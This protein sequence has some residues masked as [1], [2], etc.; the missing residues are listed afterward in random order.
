[1]ARTKR[2]DPH[3][4]GALI[5]A[6]YEHVLYYSLRTTEDGWPVP[7]SG[8]DC[9]T[10]GMREEKGADGTV[11]F[12][13][14][15]HRRDDCCVMRLREVAAFA[16]HGGP[17]SC[18]A[19]GAQ[20]KHGAVWKHTL[21]GEHIHLGYDCERNYSL[22]AD[23]SAH[24][25]KLGRLRKAAAVQCERARRSD[26]RSTFLA[27]NP[28]LEEALKT[29]HHIVRNI[30]ERFTASKFCALSDKQ[31]AL[32]MKLAHEAAQPK[33]EEK[34]VSAPTGRVDFIGEV[35]SVKT[36]D[37]DYGVQLKM[38]V[39]VQTEA[40]SWLAWMTAPNGLIDDV[41]AA[42]DDHD[43]KHLRGCTV[44]VRATLSAGKDPHFVFGKRPIGRL[45]KCP[46]AKPDE[47]KTA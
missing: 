12:I 16:Q 39:K 43:W 20:Y 37:S 10:E 2:T 11:K 1:M 6:H 22:L 21:S 25:L 14:G 40:G 7:S 47:K 44:D 29:D 32:V 17:G 38:V 36:Q 45:V 3:R 41:R 5:P 9:H 19:C 31:V 23:R 15:K 18:T 35:V 4:P 34:H 30:A 13:P 46:A 27:A 33:V 8:F 28:G 42:T 24:E 26:E